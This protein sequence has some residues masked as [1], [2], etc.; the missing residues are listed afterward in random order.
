MM[1]EWDKYMDK[2]IQIKTVD[3]LF[4]HGIF[5][6]HDNDHVKIRDIINSD[7]IIRK[8]QIATINIQNCKVMGKVNKR[9]K[10]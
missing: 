10:R 9:V 5:L 7:M 2:Y 8:D 1:I 3:K 6:K 4:F